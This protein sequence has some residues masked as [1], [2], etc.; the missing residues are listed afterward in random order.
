MG[1]AF[2]A[3]RWPA[4]GGARVTSPTAT[5]V[6]R[7]SPC[8]TSNSPPEANPT[9]VP[10]GHDVGAAVARP[11][12]DGL[13]PQRVARSEDRPAL[14]RTRPLS[15]WSRRIA[16]RSRMAARSGPRGTGAPSTSAS[17]LGAADAGRDCGGGQ[18]RR[19]P[20]VHVHPD[21][22]DE[23]VDRIH[24]Q[25]ALAQDAAHLA[26]VDQH[27]VGPLDRHALRRCRASAAITSATATLAA[28]TSCG[29][30]AGATCGRSSTENVR[31]RPG[32]LTQR[33]PR[34]PRPCVWKSVATTA[35]AGRFCPASRRYW[36][37]ES[38]SG[39]KA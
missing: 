8:R 9:A 15:T 38:V 16:S 31:S 7:P 13:A 39:T 25:R 34:R 32:S 37:V 17:A 23:P 14:R 6:V 33:R 29:A 3:A 11:H 1:A 22:Q 20:T 28:N 27:V 26:P 18:G 10:C 19:R 30:A 2:L 36:L 24:V 5:A 4:S 12:H 35:P 21:A